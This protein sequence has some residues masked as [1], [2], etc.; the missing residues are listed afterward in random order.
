MWGTW[1]AIRVKKIAWLCG[2]WPVVFMARG[3]KWHPY[4]FFSVPPPPFTTPPSPKIQS[5]GCD[6][7]GGGACIEYSCIFYSA[8]QSSPSISLPEQTLDQQLKVSFLLT[9][10]K[11]NVL[12]MN[13][14]RNKFEQKK[15]K[16]WALKEID[17]PPGKG[18]FRVLWR[19]I[20]T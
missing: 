9:S 1:C 20:T 19:E 4:A 16:L 8:A 18:A 3:P 14:L 2:P 6:K 11:R 15:R 7:G 5:R 12:R 13:C 10:S 17:P